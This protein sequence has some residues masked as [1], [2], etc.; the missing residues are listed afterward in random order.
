MTADTQ[1]TGTVIAYLR[2]LHDRI[3]SALE[4]TDGAARFRR[5]S[6][7]RP[8]G[9]GGESRVLRDGAVFEQ[10]GINF[11]HVIGGRLPASAT[12]AKNAKKKS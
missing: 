7:Q 2:S 11:S 1:S 8:E 3:T 9:G 12:A 6:W 4:T 5:D 10:A